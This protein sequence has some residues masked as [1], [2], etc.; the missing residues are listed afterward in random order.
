MLAQQGLY[1][2]VPQIRVA[3]FAIQQIDERWDEQR[4]HSENAQDQIPSTGMGALLSP[5]GY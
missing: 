1:L 5:A 3:L 2:A 4:A